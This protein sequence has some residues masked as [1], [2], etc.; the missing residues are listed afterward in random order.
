MSHVSQ[1]HERFNVIELSARRTYNVHIDS[2]PLNIAFV[3][4][5][6][7]ITSFVRCVCWSEFNCAMATRRQQRRA[8]LQVIHSIKRSQPAAAHERVKW[9]ELVKF[10]CQLFLAHR[11]SIECV[12]FGQSMADEERP[13]DSI[14]CL[15]HLLLTK[16]INEDEKTYLEFMNS[17]CN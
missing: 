12:L 5:K 7:V 14:P 16:F 9:I 2:M 10:I 4:T 15:L 11:R 3:L 1:S 17:K 6:Y 13:I 8:S